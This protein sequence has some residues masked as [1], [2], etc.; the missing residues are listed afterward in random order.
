[1]RLDRL[2]HVLIVMAPAPVLTACA[3]SDDEKTDERRVERSDEQTDAGVDAGNV[4]P[5]A[6]TPPVDAGA[7]DPCFCSPEAACCDLSG[8]QARVIDGFE[9]CWG[10]TCS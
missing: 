8:D 1:M 3:T 5:D 10:T 6:T 4:T 7:P 2:F 9:C